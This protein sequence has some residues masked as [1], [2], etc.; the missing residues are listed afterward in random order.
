MIIRL[1][2]YCQCMENTKKSSNS[3]DATT[4]TES[5][6]NINDDIKE[7]YDVLSEQF[8]CLLAL[9]NPHKVVLPYP[10]ALPL[11]NLYKA[12][13]LLPPSDPNYVAI[14]T[15]TSSTKQAITSK[16]K[17]DVINNSSSS[18]PKTTVVSTQSLTS[19]PTPT[20]TLSS[21]PIPNSITQPFA[22]QFFDIESITNN[23]LSLTSN[24]SASTT[25]NV[26]NSILSTTT[27]TTI[28][29]SS[30]SVEELK[31]SSIKKTERESHKVF[32]N[33]AKRFTDGPLSLLKRALEG[34]KRI[35]A[36]IRGLRGIRGCCIGYIMAF[37]KH[38]NII[39]TDVEEEIIRKVY[40]NH[41]T[42]INDKLNKVD[43]EQEEYDP[44]KPSI[45]P[46]T[47][48]TTTSYNRIKPTITKDKRYYGQL[49]IKGNTIVSICLL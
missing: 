29:S 42:S 12:R 25:Q 23:I 11:D 35:K 4:T 16:V 8:D 46:T 44:T 28:S 18:L 22:S 49:F 39:L 14:K 34:R 30:S 7:K 37:D 48:T 32:D 17:P 45:P 15:S 24:I 26:S 47:T 41:D 36:V 33:I 40:N 10:K 2:S 19:T 27:T 3:H 1:Y 43:E 31:K 5:K 38:Y 21:P 6:I 9:N 20:P 13:V